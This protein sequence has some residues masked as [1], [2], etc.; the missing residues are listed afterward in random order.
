MDWKSHLAKVIRE[1]S[2]TSSALF[3]RFLHHCGSCA[4]MD[5][6]I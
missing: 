4:E 5:V 6:I 2:Q 1:G 3:L